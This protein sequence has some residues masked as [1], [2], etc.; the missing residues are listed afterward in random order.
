[1]RCCLCP[2]A[3]APAGMEPNALCNAATIPTGAQLHAVKFPSDIRPGICFLCWKASSLRRRDSFL[4]FI[5]LTRHRINLTYRCDRRFMNVTRR[6][7]LPGTSLR[8]PKGPVLDTHRGGIRSIRI[9]TAAPIA[10]EVASFCLYIY[11]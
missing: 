9:L 7:P 6:P 8:H 10:A 1:M 11:F 5:P 4:L 2:G 3:S